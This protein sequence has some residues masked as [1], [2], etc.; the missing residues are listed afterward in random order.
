MMVDM[1]GP[2]LLFL[3]LSVSLGFHTFPKFIQIL[4]LAASKFRLHN[5][6][7]RGI[8][9]IENQRTKFKEDLDTCFADLMP[10][11]MYLY[12]IPDASTTILQKVSDLDKALIDVNLPGIT[13]QLFEMAM[14]PPGARAKA[15]LVIIRGNGTGKTKTME[16]VKRFLLNNYDDIFSVAVTFSG[17]WK[18]NENE[19]NLFSKY[20]YLQDEPVMQYLLSTRLLSMFYG[21][22]LATIQCMVK[23][24]FSQKKKEIIEATVDHLICK[25]R[26]WGRAIS[27][28]FLF[29]DDA[30]AVNGK[31]LFNDDKDHFDV[32]QSA[33]LDTDYKDCNT[34]IMIASKDV[35][36]TGYGWCCSKFISGVIVPPFLHSSKLFE[37]FGR[38]Q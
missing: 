5:N 8:E 15:P 1:F 12:G 20:T 7:Q 10:H 11:S 9:E 25:L 18:I 27:Y 3:Y 33:V 31:E 35:T 13:E 17:K 2:L 4:P 34:A 19:R 29:V 21:I 6:G 38:K 37:K 28:F 32:V 24:L 22:D 14:R 30:F 23:G 36:A 26:E 16:E